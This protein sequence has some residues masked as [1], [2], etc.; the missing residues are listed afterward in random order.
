MFM[1]MITNVRE[2]PGNRNR[3]IITEVGMLDPKDS[4]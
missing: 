2:T 4:R 3:L 1:S